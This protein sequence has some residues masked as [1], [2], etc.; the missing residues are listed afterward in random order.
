MSIRR[1]KNYVALLVSAAFVFSSVVLAQ[2]PVVDASNTHAIDRQA[3]NANTTSASAETSGQGELFYQLQ[4]LQQ[5]VMQL[6]GVVEEQAYLLK[7]VKEQ[8]MKRYIDMDRRLGEMATVTAP[9]A[10]TANPTNLGVGVTTETAPTVVA[11]AGEREIYDA[12]YLLVKQR[13]FDEALEAFGQFLVDFPQ[14][15]YSPNS[16]YW[17]GELYQVINPPDLEAARQSFV[18][19]L[20]QYPSHFK[21]PDAMYKL[22][23]VYFLKGDKNKA[24]TLLEQVIANYSKGTNSSAADKARQFINANY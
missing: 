22:G 24:R 16:Y 23:K 1:V 17:M 14:G 9:T 20:D 12:A 10:T 7:Q 21:V 3:L 4:L 6:R 13:R 19:L 11:A 8:N 18:Q 15:K 2:A 5:E